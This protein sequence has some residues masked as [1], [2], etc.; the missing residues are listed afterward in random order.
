MLIARHFSLDV[1]TP[2]QS[3][4]AECSPLEDGD[5]KDVLRRAVEGLFNSLY[6]V[7][8]HTHART[9]THTV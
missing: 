4:P 7:H 3:L 9:H 5:D 2:I 1:T 6:G 8:T